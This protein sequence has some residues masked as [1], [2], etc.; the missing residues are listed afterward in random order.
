MR[1]RAG[2]IVQQVYRSSLGRDTD[3]GSP[4]LQQAE[5]GG[6]GAQCHTNWLGHLQEM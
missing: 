6:R 1:M 3:G 2:C 5:T 4:S